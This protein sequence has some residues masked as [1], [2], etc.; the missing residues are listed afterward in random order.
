MVSWVLQPGK[1]HIFLVKGTVHARFFLVFSSPSA[2]SSPLFYFSLPVLVS[3]LLR[4][5]TLAPRVP[6]FLRGFSFCEA[7]SRGISRL[8]HLLLSPRSW[9]RS[10][11]GALLVVHSFFPL[12]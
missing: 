6:V 11:F 10:L 8:S 7:S 5:Q 9:V 3:T 12:D 1:L 2:S 4:N